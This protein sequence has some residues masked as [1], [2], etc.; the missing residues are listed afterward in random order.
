MRA[1]ARPAVAASLLAFASAC[2]MPVSDPAAASS[3]EAEA[4]ATSYV[5]IAD[6]WTTGADQ[7]AWFAL[8]ST[9]AKQFNYIC[10][11]TFCNGDYL[12]LT[13]LGLTCAVSSVKGSIRDCTWVFAGS[14]ERT[15]GATGALTSSIPTFQC[16]FAPKTTAKGLV[17]SLTSAGPT[18]A[19]HRPLPGLST[20]LY[21]VV[22]DCMLH[23]VGATPI[24]PPSSSAKYVGAVDSFTTQPAQDSWLAARDALRAGFDDVCGDTFCGGDYSNLQALRFECSVNAKTGT[25]KTCAWNFAG[26]YDTIGPKGALSVHAKSFSCPVPVSGTASKLAAVLTAPG[27]VPAIRRPLPGGSRSAYDALTG[28]L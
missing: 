19:L 28:C 7:T 21:D 6:F 5:D 23:P 1:F 3:D 22:A 10:G 15:D 24:A 18:E 12:N 26:S 8:R 20:S 4:L 25:L 16:H 9:L 14:Y 27:A 2:V 11:D 13:P 17:S